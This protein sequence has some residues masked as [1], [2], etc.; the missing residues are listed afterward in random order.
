MRRVGNFLMTGCFLSALLIS[1]LW[2]QTPP[3]P[4]EK[5]LSA[6]RRAPADP[7]RPGAAHERALTVPQDTITPTILPLPQPPAQAIEIKITVKRYSAEARRTFKKIY[8]TPKINE[9]EQIRNA[10]RR[11][12]GCD[13]WYPYYL[14]KDIEDKISEKISIRV[15]RMKGKP[16]FEKDAFLYVFKRTF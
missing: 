9:K 3:N 7:I 14:A 6:Q 13:V 12:F 8:N 16:K 11:V 1:P 4:A 2:A 5:G 15:C 10:W